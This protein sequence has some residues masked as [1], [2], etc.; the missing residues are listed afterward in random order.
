M[1]IL[2]ESTASTFETT[3]GSSWE[4]EEAEIKLQWISVIENL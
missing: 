4:M 3:A 2:D 1:P